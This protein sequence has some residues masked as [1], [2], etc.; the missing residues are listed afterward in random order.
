MVKQEEQLWS[1]FL[2]PFEPRPQAVDTTHCFAM[3]SL[4]SIIAEGVLPCSGECIARGVECIA[5]G[6]ECTECSGE[7]ISCSREC[8]ACSV[9]CMACSVECISCSVECITCGGECIT[10]SVEWRVYGM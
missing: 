7:C 2:Q 10:C 8:M 6:G 3:D 4:L 5:C 1:S 9:E